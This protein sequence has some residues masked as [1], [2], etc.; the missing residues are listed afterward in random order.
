[1]SAATNVILFVVP[2]PV[3]S[4]YLENQFGVEEHKLGNYFFFL[5]FSYAIACPF[6]D[7]TILSVTSKRICIITGFFVFSLGFFIAAPSFF[8]PKYL[9][10][11]SYSLGICGCFALD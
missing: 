11:K 2:E 9:S 5:P 4:D 8:F 3:L 6:V 7:H 1:M 10:C